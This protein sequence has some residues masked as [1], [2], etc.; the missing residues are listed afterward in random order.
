MIRAFYLVCAMLTL[1]VI[2]FF[3]GTAS[4]SAGATHPDKLAPEMQ[5]T[6]KNGKM[7]LRRDSSLRRDSDFQQKCRLEYRRLKEAT[8]PI[9]VARL[10]RKWAADRLTRFK[11]HAEQGRFHFNLIRDSGDYLSKARR[12]LRY[13]AYLG[14]EK[15][16]KQIRK[17]ILKVIAR[18]KK[19]QQQYRQDIHEECQW[20]MQQYPEKKQFGW[21]DLRARQSFRQ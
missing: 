21:K 11:S 20:H 7:K 5:I 2:T 9:Q 18:F 10:C 4:L 15:S 12:Q 19:L 3:N 6:K 13:A 8:G 16:V 14:H 17:K 1:A